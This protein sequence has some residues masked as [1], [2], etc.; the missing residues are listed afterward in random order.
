MHVWVCEKV[1]KKLYPE[2]IASINLSQKKLYLRYKKNS[3]ILSDLANDLDRL[4][5]PVCP[6]ISH[7]ENDH[8]DYINLGVAFFVS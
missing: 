5:Y 6:N 7:R 4:G 3:L 2:L 1:L 8:S